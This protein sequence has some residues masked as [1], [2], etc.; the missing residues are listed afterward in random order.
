ME[1]GIPPLDLQAFV[2][3]YKDESDST[4]GADAV[5]DRLMLDSIYDVSNNDLDMGFANESDVRG[6]PY[7]SDEMRGDESNFL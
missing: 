5:N 6:R 4:T 2:E 3:E 1:K 7:E